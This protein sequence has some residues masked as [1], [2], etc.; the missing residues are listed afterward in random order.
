M[1]YV[2]SLI[3]WANRKSQVTTPNLNYPKIWGK[4]IT[5]LQDLEVQVFPAHSTEVNQKY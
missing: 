4:F 3:N 1:N 2:T 5:E